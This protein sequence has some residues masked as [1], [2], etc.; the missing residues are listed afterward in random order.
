[1][2]LWEWQEVQEVPWEKS[3]KR[4]IVLIT[5]MYIGTLLITAYI[6]Y[7]PLRTM[8]GHVLGIKSII[9]LG[10]VKHSKNKGWSI[11]DFKSLVMRFRIAKKAGTPEETRELIDSYIVKA[12]RHFPISFMEHSLEY[13]VKPWN[14]G[15]RLLFIF[16]YEG[17]IYWIALHTSSNASKYAKLF[18]R[19]LE[20]ME[21]EGNKIGLELKDGLEKIKLPTFVAM[22]EYQTL[23]IMAAALGM[24]IFIIFL[25]FQLGW[26]LPSNIPHGIVKREKTLVSIRKKGF[27]TN[28]PGVILIGNGMI[29]IYSFGKKILEHRIGEGVYIKGGYLNI[30][31]KDE[32]VFVSLS[33]PD[34]WRMWFPVREK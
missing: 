4:L 19:F 11:V 2:P 5:G 10:D 26:R 31:K 7:V 9:P 29:Y 8:E 34:E 23:L 15:Y 14:K 21:I 16:P 24:G 30:E 22:G 17:R 1:M 18:N 6:L 13:G 32:K 20:N 25:T 12:M 27:N 33:N 3:M 28:I